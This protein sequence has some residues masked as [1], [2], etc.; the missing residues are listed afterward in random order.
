MIKTLPINELDSKSEEGIQ[1]FNLN[2]I[3]ELNVKLNN[4]IH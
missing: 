2:V 1:Y 4:T 3:F